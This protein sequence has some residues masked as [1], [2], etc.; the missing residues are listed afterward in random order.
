MNKRISRTRVRLFLC[1][2]SAALA[3]I[4]LQ[5]IIAVRQ[6][7]EP[8]PVRR[9]SPAG[10]PPTINQSQFRPALPGYE[11]VFPRDHYSHPAFQTEWWY[12]T[13]HLRSATGKTFGYQI[14]FFRSALM[15]R[16]INRQ[17]KWATRD[18]IFAHLALTDE[19]NQK[20]YFTDRISRSAAGLAGARNTPAN[21][22]PDIWLDDWNMQF[23]SGNGDQQNAKAFG[24]ADDGSTKFGIE[25][26]HSALKPLAIHGQNGISQKSAGRG[27]ASHYYSFTR[28]KSAG[29]I[30]I[31]EQ[32]YAV[33]GESWF[34]HEFGSNQL[35]KEQAGWDWFSIQLDDG[36]ELMLYQLRLK[37]GKIDPFSSGTLVE[38]DGTTRH[39]KHN[40]YQIEVLDQW[41]SPHSKATYPSRWKVTL[42]H[43]KI[44]IEITPTVAD[45]E[46]NT[47][48]STNV[49]Y[50]EGSVRVTGTQRGKGYVE[51]TGYETEFNG[52]F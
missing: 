45:Q 50:W 44:A 42:P 23:K 9:S 11:Y 18:V 29:K 20:F 31:G 30:R 37:S 46:L 7:P 35:S 51:M 13:G 8:G 32:E 27:R 25:L 33:S 26:S 6:Y 41:R 49:T 10:E 47:Q 38:K 15:P 14:T 34:D 36:R 39:L 12:Y 3:G 1:L 19:T 4:A 52:T 22:Q 5:R 17:S 2:L 40:E 43:E 28:L 16:L 21:G 48:R 24:I